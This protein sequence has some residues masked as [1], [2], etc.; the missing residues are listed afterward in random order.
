MVT[1]ALNRRTLATAAAAAAA[2]AAGALP[3]A[4][5]AATP[6]DVP[7]PISPRAAERL[8][9]DCIRGAPTTADAHEHWVTSCLERASAGR[10]R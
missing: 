1:T 8:Y 5:S 4:S 10:A 6:D 2:L 9:L 3:C 7:G